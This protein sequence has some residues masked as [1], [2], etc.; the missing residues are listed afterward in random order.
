M[1]FARGVASDLDS[2]GRRRLW[3]VELVLAGGAPRSPTD[4]LELAACLDRFISVGLAYGES[5][6]R[7]SASRAAPQWAPS[8]DPAGGGRAPNE[9]QPRP[10]TGAPPIASGVHERVASVPE[11][12][13]ADGTIVERSQ[14]SVGQAQISRLSLARQQS[15]ARPNGRSVPAKSHLSREEELA[16]EQQFLRQRAAAPSTIDDVIRFLRQRGDSV[17]T[18]EGGYLVNERLVLTRD[19]LIARA[20]RYRKHMGA[21]LFAIG[22]G[23]VSSP[24]TAPQSLMM[25]ADPRCCRG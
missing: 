21:P 20:N 19:Q 22:N 3:L 13:A 25:T 16:L 8:V 17:I 15:Q 5:A 24:D 4:A 1:A 18:H 6:P 2:A 10:R 14:R 9:P 12:G 7:S 11:S 23:C